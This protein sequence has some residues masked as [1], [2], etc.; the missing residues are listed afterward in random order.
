METLNFNLITWT[1]EDQAKYQR[2]VKKEKR[3]RD[4]IKGVIMLIIA[5]AILMVA[6]LGCELASNI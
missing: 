1:A 4:K 6:A 3:N 5:T 2:L